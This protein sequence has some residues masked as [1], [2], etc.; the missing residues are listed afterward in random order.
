M[1]CLHIPIFEDNAYPVSGRAVAVD[2]QH[3]NNTTPAGVSNTY[4]NAIN[5][6]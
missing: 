6:R 1:T 5:Y 3:V 4:Y 2:W